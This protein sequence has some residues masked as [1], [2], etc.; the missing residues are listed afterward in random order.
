M[1]VRLQFARQWILVLIAALLTF[2]VNAQMTVNIGGRIHLDAALYDEDVT[3]LGSGTEFRRARAFV[4]GVLADQWNYKLQLEFGDG[5]VD[6]KDAFIQYTGLNVGKLKI[7]QFKVPF[8]LEELASS[9]YI[10]FMERGAPNA[11]V[12]SRRIGVG[13]E[14]ASGNRTWSAAVFGNEAQDNNEDEGL[15]IAGRFTIAPQLGEGRFWHFG[16]AASYEEPATTDDAGGVRFR[17]RP[18]SHVTGTRLVN[19]GT[20]ANVSNIMKTGLEGAYVSGGLSVHQFLKVLST[21][22]VLILIKPS[23]T[24]KEHSIN[25]SM[26]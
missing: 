9:K 12:P 21:Q 24:F 6:M 14:N 10:T 22:G 18:E 13:L 5:S 16:V 2:N 11:F 23:M 3:E 25:G 1:T 26:T 15:G 20:I 17:A 7:G 8:S 19:G 4:S